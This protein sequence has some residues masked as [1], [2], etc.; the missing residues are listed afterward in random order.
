MRISTD[1]A[2]IGSLIPLY[3]AAQQNT[4]LV[5]AGTT[6]SAFGPTALLSLAQGTPA[7]VVAYDYTEL[8][9]AAAQI[10][11]PI[12]PQ[13]SQKQRKAEQETIKQAT[14][15]RLNSRYD[16]ARR[17]LEALL[18]KNPSNGLAVHGLGAIELDL[19]NYEKAEQ[20]FHKAHHLAPEHGFDRDAANAEILQ[21]DDAYVLEQARRLTERGETRDDAT[22]LLVALTRRSPSNAVA[23]TLLA[24]NLIRSGDA[25]RGLAEYQLAISSADRGQLEQI[26]SKLASLVEVAP[27]AAYLRNLLGQT[28]LKLGKPEQAAET[29]ALATRLSDNDPLYQ[30]DEALAHVALGREALDRNDLL[31]AMSAFK[32]AQSLDPRGDEVKLGLAEGYMARGLWRMRIGDPGRAIDELSSAKSVLGTIENADLRGRIAEA[33][34]RAGCI[35]EQRRLSSGDKVGDEIVAFQAAYDLDPENLTYRNK[36]AETHSLIG[37]EFLA[38]GNHRDAAYAYQA[39]YE[40]NSNEETYK[41]NA[42]SAFLA[43]GDERSAA[44]DH[45]QAITAYQAA[46]DLDESNETAKFS[47]A[48]AFNTRGLFYR[49]LGADFYE[50]AR[51]DFLAALNLY[52]DN[53]DYQDNY[54]SVS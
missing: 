53:E 29:L 44:Y 32:T 4:A 28:E 25:A 37:D 40:V 54:D 24:E 21:H 20:Y 35:L 41:G 38:E 49:S 19:G 11:S 50:Q 34:Y 51:N 8:V 7:S 36:L 31:A 39:A 23:R 1:A 42:I 45:H 27:R 26:E 22:R 6:T 5:G 13:I 3:T 9:R 2:A 16:D 47:L 30:A 46:Y 10:R 14:A 17:L 43:W 15:L 12:T 48:E 18:A 52:P 33:F